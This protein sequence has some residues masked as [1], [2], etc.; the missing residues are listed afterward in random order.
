[1]IKLISYI[2][3]NHR[4]K[5][6]EESLRLIIRSVNKINARALKIKIGGRMKNVDAI[7]MRTEKLIPKVADPW[8]K[9][10]HFMLMLTAR[11]PSTKKAVEVGRMLENNGFSFYRRT[12]IPSTTLMKQN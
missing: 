9:N 10:A 4:S 3:N 11:I 5:N 12:C 7:P 1:M 6:V 8:A 2:A